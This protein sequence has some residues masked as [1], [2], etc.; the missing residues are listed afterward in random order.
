MLPGWYGFGS[1]LAPALEEFGDEV[2]SRML[3][4]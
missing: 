2:F 1:G 3:L 4:E